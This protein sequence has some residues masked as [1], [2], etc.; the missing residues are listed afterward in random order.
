MAAHIPVFVVA[1][2]GGNGSCVFMK[3]PAMKPRY[4]LRRLCG[5][6]SLER[7]LSC[8]KYKTFVYERNKRMNYH[9]SLLV[10]SI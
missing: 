3:L 10:V 1:S 7:I 4:L 5:V 6:K 8:E 9:L 2:D